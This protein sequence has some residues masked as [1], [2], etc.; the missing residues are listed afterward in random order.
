[1]VLPVTGNNKEVPNSGITLMGLLENASP[2]QESGGMLGLFWWIFQWGCGFWRE[3]HR[4]YDQ[5][6][7]AVCCN[8][9]FSKDESAVVWVL[10][11]TCKMC[12]IQSV[13]HEACT[14]IYTIFNLL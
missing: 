11:L 12:G 1:M 3:V 9:L 8:V 4:R 14:D 2:S 10:F 6:V 5:S 13:R 7:N